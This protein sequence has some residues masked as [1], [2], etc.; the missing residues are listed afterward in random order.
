MFVAVFR[1]VL[2][3]FFLVFIMRLMG[4]RQIGQLQPSELII[5]MLISEI[6]TTPIEDEETSLL[7]AFIPILLLA[8]LEIGTS[9]AAL[10]FI[11][12]RSVFQGNSIV[13]IRNGKIDCKQLARLRYSVDDL[14]ESLRAK[15]VFDI[16]EVQYAIVET[17]GTLSV[18]LKPGYRNATVNDVNAEPENKGLPRILISDGRMIDSQIKQSVMTREEVENLLKK[19]NLGRKEVLLL[20]VDEYGNVN[21][22]KKS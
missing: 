14:L 4:K 15:D 12:I 11:R 20:T 6:A 5:T 22:V 17:D 1:T 8:L 18:L 2:I 13:V 21:I 10:K 19:H 9:F 16:G 7:F 3:Y